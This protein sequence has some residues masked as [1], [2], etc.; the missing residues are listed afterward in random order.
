MFN[1][2]QQKFIINT[3]GRIDS[4]QAVYKPYSNELE[5]LRAQIVALEGTPSS[6]YVA[7]LWKQ[8][9]ALSNLPITNSLNAN[10]LTY[11]RANS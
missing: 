4:L 7:D 11:Y 5:W 2:T 9:L 10:K 3:L 6:N 8:L 1:D